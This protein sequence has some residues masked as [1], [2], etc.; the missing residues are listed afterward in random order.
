MSAINL[1]TTLKHEQFIEQV[2]RESGQPVQQCYQ[3][4]KCTAGC[5]IAFSMDVPPNRVMRMV[6]LGLRETA[7]SCNSIWLCAYCSTCSVRCPK[8]VNLAQVMDALRIIAG[9][10]KRAKT[11]RARHV[12][13]FN[14]NFLNSI[15]RYG[16]LHE[17]E[18]MTM[19]NLK[20]GQPFKNADTGLYM[21]SRGKLKFLIQKTSQMDQVKQIFARVKELEEK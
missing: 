5:P 21:L 18:T 2:S 7:L 10:E 6:Q 17:F 13:L 3:C 9:K 15:R 19:Y 20:S 16:R 1:T 12:E 8:N 11:A 14:R 4:G